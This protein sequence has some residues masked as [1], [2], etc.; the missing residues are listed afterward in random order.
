LR[1]HER[2]LVLSRGSETVLR[3]WRNGQPMSLSVT[4]QLERNA[5]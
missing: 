2:V 3:V 5:A 4:P 1:C